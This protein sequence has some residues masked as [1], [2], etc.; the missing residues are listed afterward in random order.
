MS[1]PAD[2]PKAIQVWRDKFQ[3]EIETLYLQLFDDLANSE[4]PEGD[5]ARLGQALLRAKQESIKEIQ[6]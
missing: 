5:I 6:K 3:G 1:T 4:L 2:T